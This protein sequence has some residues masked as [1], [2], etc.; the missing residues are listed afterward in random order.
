LT[1]PSTLSAFISALESGAVAG[2]LYWN[3]QP[4]R[5]DNGYVVHGTDVYAMYY[6][7]LDTSPGQA[8]ERAKAQLLRNHAYAMSGLS[9]PADGT[10]KTPLITGITGGAGAAAISWRGAAI[11]DTYTVERATA[12][13]SGPWTVICNQCATDQQTPWTDTGYAGGTAFYR[14]K[15]HNLSNVAGP[16]SPVFQYN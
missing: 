9:V 16:Y 2:D 10:P 13:S 7:G 15:G 3:L 4:H 1:S 14:V 6:P 8:G 11:A 5:D 12:G